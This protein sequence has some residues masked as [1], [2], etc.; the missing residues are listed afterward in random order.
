MIKQN[1]KPS[2]EQVKTEVRG[3]I[4]SV[5]AQCDGFDD[6]DSRRAIWYM[7]STGFDAS[8]WLACYNPT[9]RGWEYDLACYLDEAF[10]ALRESKRLSTLADRWMLDKSAPEHGVICSWMV[11]G[12]ADCARDFIVA[13]RS[14]DD[15]WYE[16]RLDAE[17][18]NIK[19][20]LERLGIED[21]MCKHE[22]AAVLT[23]YILSHLT[24]LYE[25]SG[26]SPADINPHASALEK[27]DAIK[28]HT[29]GDDAL[30]TLLDYADKQP[31]FEA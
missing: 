9:G 4:A 24:G 23:L 28:H 17:E 18:L 25:D 31:A 21:T 7:V 19:P 11:Q 12:M 10:D 26:F 29:N 16:L 22:V 5:I 6:A 30:I 13:L 15:Y 3:F 1:V 14:D 2:L 27:W 8:K 20:R